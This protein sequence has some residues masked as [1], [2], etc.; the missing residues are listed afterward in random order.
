MN[1]VWKVGTLFSIPVKV[2]SSIILVFGVVAYV[3]YEYNLSQE[4]IIGFSA[5]IICVFI[6]VLLHE[7]GHILMARYY[8]IETKDIILSAVGGLARLKGTIKKPNQE[9]MISLAGPL[10]NV[11]LAFAILIAFKILGIGWLQVEVDYNIFANTIG[12][13]HMLMIMN[14]FLC[15][16]NLIPAFPMDGGRI[17]RALLSYKMPVLK[18]TYIAMIVGRIFALAF[19]ILGVYNGILT[20]ILV[21]L[22]VYILAGVEYGALKKSTK[23]LA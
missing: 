12:F 16:F 9:L 21:G 22:V 17:L 11:V 6:C 15:L 19:I 20:L 10:V 5:Y 3:C 2:H 8:G 18:A 14:A 23:K 13:I 7:Y 1:Q 4:E